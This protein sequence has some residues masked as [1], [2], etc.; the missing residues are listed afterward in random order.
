MLHCAGG[1][2]ERVLTARTGW[3]EVIGLLPR[4]DRPPGVFPTGST[5]CFWRSEDWVGDW[6]AS[7]AQIRA[8]LSEGKSRSRV[9]K[10]GKEDLFGHQRWKCRQRCGWLDLCRQQE[11]VWP[12]L[13]SQW[14]QEVDY[15]R[16]FLWLLC[17]CCQDRRKRHRWNFHAPDWER[18][19]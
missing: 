7:S 19:W 1:A 14:H 13:R 16:H 9:F 12:V 6:P 8:A 3:V 15:K 5:W 4:V 11:S 2:F 10:R 17:H 18:A